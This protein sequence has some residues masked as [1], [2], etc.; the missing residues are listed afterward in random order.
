[1][2]R[3]Y[4]A[5]KFYTE[6]DEVKSVETERD[7]LTLTS[8][9]KN[10]IKLCSDFGFALGS[11]KATLFYLLETY[12]GDDDTAKLRK[13]IMETTDKLRLAVTETQIFV[14]NLLINIMRN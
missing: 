13:D 4:R 6:E 10:Y 2:L 14:E 5:W 3:L 8:C 12:S 1:M 9:Y 11:M 7:K